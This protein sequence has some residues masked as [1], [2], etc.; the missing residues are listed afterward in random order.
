MKTLVIIL[1]FALAGAGATFAYLKWKGGSTAPTPVQHHAGD[2]HDHGPGQDHDHDAPA[3]APADAHGAGH[4]ITAAAGEETCA[5][6]R[7]PKSKDG[8]CHPEVIAKMGFC[9]AHD[10]DEAFCTRCS[11]ILIAA[12]KAE[13]DRCAEHSLPESQCATCKGSGG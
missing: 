8:F 11:P 9:K 1:A 5:K 13:G 2:G 4:G 12:F 6:H 3:G 10:V 7:I